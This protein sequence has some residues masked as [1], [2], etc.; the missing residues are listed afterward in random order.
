MLGNIRAQT[1]EL[2][3]ENSDKYSAVYCGLCKTLGRRYG[4]LSRFALN[5]DMA[6]VALLY[7]VL[8]QNTPSISKETCFANPFKRKSVAGQ[9]QGMDY[10]ADMLVLLTYYKIWDNIYDERFLKRLFSLSLLPFVY[11]KFKKAQKLHGEIALVLKTQTEQQQIFER[12][13]ADLDKLCL[14]TC[15]MTK[16]ILQGCVQEGELR[17]N[18]GHFGFFMGRVIYLL[19]ALKD[20]LEDE[21]EGKFNI[22]NIQHLSLQQS[23]EECFMSLGEMAYWYRHLPVDSEK[24]ILDNIIYLGIARSI[25]FSENADGRKYE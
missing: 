23:K 16:A 9:T 6:F 7:D 4:V 14:P 12:E 25:E 17:E 18:C 8:N 11:F 10:A 19:D 24:E 5:Y 13:N 2:K 3:S 15:L 21:K 22:F 20:R 1:C